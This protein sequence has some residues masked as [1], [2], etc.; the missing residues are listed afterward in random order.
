MTNPIENSQ[1]IRNRSEA[2]RPLAKLAAE[3]SPLRER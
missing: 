2:K 1:E 3:G